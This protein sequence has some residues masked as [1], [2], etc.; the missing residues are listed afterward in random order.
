MESLF[1]FLQGIMPGLAGL[2]F[3]DVILKWVMR[4]AVG[5]SKNNK[6]FNLKKDFYKLIPLLVS[7]GVFIILS[8]IAFWIGMG[9][10]DWTFSPSIGTKGACSWHGGV[11]PWNGDLAF[12]VIYAMSVMT[13]VFVEGLIARKEIRG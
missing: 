7:I 12:Q 11:R 2:I 1:T 13:S 4:K 3:I 8:I 9:C 5:L 10:N 6:P